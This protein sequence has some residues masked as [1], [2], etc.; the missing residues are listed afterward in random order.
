MLGLGRVVSN[1]RHD[2]RVGI[3]EL[4]RI[5]EQSPL[6]AVPLSPAYVSRI[7]RETGEVD[8]AKVGIDT[9]WALGV[10]LQLDPLALFVM[11]RPDLPEVLLS[12]ERRE[13]LFKIWDVPEVP[14]GEFLRSRRH[15]LGLSISEISF[16]AGNTPFACFGISSGFLSQVETDFRGMSKTVS[17]DKLW[18]LGVVLGV[19][20]LALYALS[21][22]LDQGMNLRRHRLFLFGR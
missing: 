9:L 13:S 20:P 3:R 6:V 10:S 16:S 22:G 7:E 5:S 11:S 19:D 17:G 14:L 4:C 15:S 18:A 1:R 21:R 12:R 8:L 2:A